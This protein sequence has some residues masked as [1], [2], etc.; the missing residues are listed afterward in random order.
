MISKFKITFLLLIIFIKSQA[1]IFIGKESDISFFSKSPIENIEAHNTAT[2]PVLNG[3]TGEI[4]FKI[5]VTSFNFKSALMQEHFNENYMESDKF[6]VA[7][8]Q[9][10]INEPIDYAKEGENKV[11]VYGVMTVHGVSQNVLYTGIISVN[12]GEVILTSAFKLRLADFD[13]KVPA[14]YEQ[15]IAK[16]MDVEVKA[17]LLPYVKM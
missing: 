10:K 16:D 2:K 9:G 17:T 11:S 8:F 4:L 13:I 7:T 12:K 6:P 15:S 3:G 1:Q 5:P 14:L